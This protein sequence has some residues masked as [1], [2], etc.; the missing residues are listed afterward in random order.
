MMWVNETLAFW[1]RRDSWLLTILRLTSRSFAG[2]RA[3]RCGRWEVAALVHT[4]GDRGC[5]TDKG[6][7]VGQIAVNVV[8]GRL[9][10]PSAPLP[11]PLPR[12]VSTPPEEKNLRQ[13]ELTDIG[14]D[15]YRASIWSTNQELRPNASSSWFISGPLGALDSDAVMRG[16]Y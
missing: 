11:F 4:F 13:A 5:G 9:G 15:S 3:H 2:K 10:D 8:F 1:A 16:C 6:S 7:D 12:N 14:L